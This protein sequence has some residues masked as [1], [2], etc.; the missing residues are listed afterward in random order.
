[1]EMGAA[2]ETQQFLS[3]SSKSAF[4]PQDIYSNYLGTQFFNTYQDL[5]NVDPNRISE[6][7]YW[8]LSNPDNLEIK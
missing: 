5:I 8:F 6:Y 4:Y 2:K 1:M 3:G 7:I